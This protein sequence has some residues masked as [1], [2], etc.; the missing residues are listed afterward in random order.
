[1][2]DFGGIEKV[3]IVKNFATGSFWVLL[4]AN[5]ILKEDLVFFDWLPTTIFGAVRTMDSELKARSLEFA[6]Q[7]KKTAWF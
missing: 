1:M 2:V 4:H 3:K 6:I 7:S 5:F